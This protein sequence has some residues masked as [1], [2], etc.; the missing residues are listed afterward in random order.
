ML[1]AATVATLP[2]HLLVVRLMLRQNLLPHL[3]LALVDIR[4]ELVTVLLDG[5]LLI[6]I[7]GN[8]DLL[9]AYGFLLGIVELGNVWMLQGLLSCQALIW[10]ELKQTLKQV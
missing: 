2:P 8:E 9:C 1:L 10:V 3:L 6:I 4:V 5:E 7:D